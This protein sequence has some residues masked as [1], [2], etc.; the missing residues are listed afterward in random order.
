MKDRDFLVIQY[1]MMTK[2]HLKPGPMRDLFAIIYNYSKD[3]IHTY[4]ASMDVLAEQLGVSERHAQDLVR[5]LLES[6]YINREQKVVICT[7]GKNRESKHAK[8]EYTTNY[9]AL[10]ARADAGEDIR[11]QPM[12]RRAKMGG[13]SSAIVEDKMGGESSPKGVVNATKMGGES[14]PKWVVK[15]PPNNKDKEGIVSISL[16][17]ESAHAREAEQREFYK[18]FFLRNAANP[19]EE[20][21]R[22]EGWYQARG[23]QAKDGTVY[24]TPAKRAGLAYAW[25][26]KTGNRFQKSETTDNYFRFIGA[27]FALAEEIGG[28]DPYCFIDTHSG[29]F[30]HGK[31][32]IRWKCRPEVQKW[33]MDNVDKARAIKEKYFGDQ[34]TVLYV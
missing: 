6:G 24:D 1:D 26:I 10:L 19:A 9:E 34:T 21:R 4:R 33:V 11:P 5:I 25:E 30:E 2:L 7:K 17:N 22:F 31:G 18:I 15:V 14:S 16:S 8:Y 29:Y 3:G 12:K 13:E 27:L 28:I 23:W 32:T 20:V